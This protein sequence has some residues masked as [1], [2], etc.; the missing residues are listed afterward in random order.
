MEKSPL[1]NGDLYMDSI[2]KEY[3]RIYQEYVDDEKRQKIIKEL[4]PLIETFHEGNIYIVDSYKKGDF[5]KGVE[6]VISDTLMGLDYI[7]DILKNESETLID[8]INNIKNFY[9]KLK[10]LYQEKKCDIE[11]NDDFLVLLK[12][13]KGAGDKHEK[14]I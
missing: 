9:I 10:K 11:I 6:Q 2:E 1:M 12:R 5:S 8:M 4:I 13:L 14:K 7:S 3:V